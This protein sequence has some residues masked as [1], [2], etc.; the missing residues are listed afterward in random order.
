M[1][2]VQTCALPISGMKLGN[3]INDWTN[4]DDLI[5]DFYSNKK[6]KK[7]GLSGMFAASLELTREGSIKI[8]QEKMFEKIMIKRT[9]N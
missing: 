8:L 6:M 5:P 2:G 9:A 4:L 7:T 3:Q 1:T